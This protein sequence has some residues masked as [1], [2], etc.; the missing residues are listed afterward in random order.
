MPGIRISRMI[1]LLSLEVA[2]LKKFLGGGKDLN[3]KFADCKSNRKCSSHR[4][5]VVD[6]INQDFLF[7]P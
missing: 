7:A 3:V 5:V 1:Q 2:R 6:H 4:F